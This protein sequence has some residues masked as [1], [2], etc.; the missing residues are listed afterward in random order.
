MG[1]RLAVIVLVL[2]LGML[3]ARLWVSDDGL[4]EVARLGHQIQ[5]QQAENARLELRN[6]R[7]EAEIADLRTGREAIEE[8]AR[9][10]LGL[11]GPQ[12]TFFVFGAGVAA[13]EPRG[14]LA[15]EP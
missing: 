14:T 4:R 8:R 6:R 2:L 15:M 12:E 9:T 1:L 10:D 13:P 3:Q 7:L 5:L 11:I